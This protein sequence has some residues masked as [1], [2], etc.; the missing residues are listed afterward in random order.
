MLRTFQHPPGA[1]A[2]SF[3]ASRQWRDGVIED[4]HQAIMHALTQYVRQSRMTPA[5]ISS[6]V[7]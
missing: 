1:E 4:R 6:S 2:R 7:F 3:I 5:A